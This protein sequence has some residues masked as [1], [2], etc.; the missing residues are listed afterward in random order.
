MAKKK[1]SSKMRS[2]V[3]KPCECDGCE[4]CGGS[5]DISANTKLRNAETGTWH[6]YCPGCAASAI[7]DDPHVEEYTS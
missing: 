6:F 4:A 5:C 1:I 2:I 3:H 7:D